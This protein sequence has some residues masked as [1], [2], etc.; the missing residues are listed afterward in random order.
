MPRKERQHTHSSLARTFSGDHLTADG[1]RTASAVASLSFVLFRIVNKDSRVCS[2]SSVA[3]WAQQLFSPT[4]ILCY[5][6]CY[7]V[8]SSWRLLLIITKSG[9]QFLF[10]IVHLLE[11]FVMSSSTCVSLLNYISCISAYISCIFVSVYILSIFRS[12][13]QKPRPENPRM[14]QCLFYYD[15]F[16]FIIFLPSPS[17]WLLKD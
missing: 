10:Y 16:C 17:C 12:N 8:V 13:C 15:D 5:I 9:I 1:G 4:Y 14:I 7:L 6:E 3:W 2:W 11:C